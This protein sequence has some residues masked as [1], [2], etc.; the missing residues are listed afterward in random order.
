MIEFW[1][2]PHAEDSVV[3]SFGVL[4]LLTL[5]NTYFD[6]FVAGV[7][8]LLM[9]VKD[10]PNTMQLCYQLKSLS[11]L[12]AN[13]PIAENLQAWERFTFVGKWEIYFTLPFKTNKYGTSIDPNSI[14][15]SFTILFVIILSWVIRWKESTCQSE[16]G[17]MFNKLDHA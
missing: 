14:Q 7:I 3:W 1:H 5:E 11:V 2:W 8:P 6:I 4:S 10:G 9:I 17:E 16:F 13:R 12:Q 15:Y